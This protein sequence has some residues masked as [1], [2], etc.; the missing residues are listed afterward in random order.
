MRLIGD[1]KVAALPRQ[2]S[3]THNLIILA[4]SKYPEEREFY[5]R[6]SIQERW[7]SRELERQFKASLF[8]RVVLSPPKVSA[9]ISQNRPEII[10]SFRDIMVLFI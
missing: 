1:I 5:L 10:A 3:W 2:L 9:T 6:M 7:S 8:E 4:K